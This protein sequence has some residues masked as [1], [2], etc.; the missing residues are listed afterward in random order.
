[1]PEVN[2]RWEPQ[3]PMGTWIE[4]EFEGQKRVALILNFDPTDGQYYVATPDKDDPKTATFDMEWIEHDDAFRRSLP[5]PTVNGPGCQPDYVFI[6]THDHR[7]L[8]E[9]QAPYEA[10]A[11]LDALLTNYTAEDARELVQKLAMEAIAEPETMIAFPESD[12]SICFAL[13]KGA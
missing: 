9:G 5:P 4:C 13:V 7:L 1:M 12:S 2:G 11:N 10:F 8:P 6:I 3:F